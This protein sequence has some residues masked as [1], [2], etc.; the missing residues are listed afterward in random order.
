MLN[1]VNI[2]WFAEGLACNY[3]LRVQFLFYRE[4]MH[5]LHLVNNMCLLLI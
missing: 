4:N 5:N 3:Y 2:L 1:A